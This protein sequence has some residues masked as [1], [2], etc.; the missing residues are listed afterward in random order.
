MPRSFWRLPAT[1]LICVLAVPALAVQTWAIPALDVQTSAVPAGANTAEPVAIA[2]PPTPVAVDEDTAEPAPPASVLRRHRLTLNAPAVV[3][4][5]LA[6]SYEVAI[7]SQFALFAEGRV[8]LM[9]GGGGGVHVYPLGEAPD[10]FL[11]GAGWER[12]SLIGF[13][14][15]PASE[16]H[17]PFVEAGWT[18][19]SGG[20]LTVG[21]LAGATYFIRLDR[22]DSG[23]IPRLSGQIGLAL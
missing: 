23:W 18:W 8:G 12:V 2:E 4:G 11:V 5:M 6:I 3:V 19:Q 15:A 22:D 16:L 21:V 17:G 1:F 13:F 10:G 20:L 9:T 7:A 14:D